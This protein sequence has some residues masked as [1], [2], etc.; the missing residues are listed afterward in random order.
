VRFVGNVGNS[1]ATTAIAPTTRLETFAREVL[2][3][4]PQQTAE[5]LTPT[6]CSSVQLCTPCAESCIVLLIAKF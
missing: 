6:L 1:L 2:L 3:L 4:S 5:R